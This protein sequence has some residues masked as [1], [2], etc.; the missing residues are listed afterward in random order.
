MSHNPDDTFASLPN[1]APTAFAPGVRFDDYELI[2]KLGQGGMGE[3]WRAKEIPAAGRDVAIKFVPK[4]IEK[5]EEEMERVAEMFRQV[6]DMQHE[7]ICPL[8]TMKRT[9]GFGTYIVMKFIRGVT[10][11]KFA[12]EVRQAHG[13]FPLTAL[14]EILRP[15]AAALDYAHKK[16]VVHRDIKPGNIMLSGDPKTLEIEDVQ[17][18]DFGLAAT[19]RASMSRVSQ[20]KSSTSGTRPYMAPEQWN[21][22]FQDAATDQY[23]LAV[24]VYELLAGVFPFDSDD[25]EALRLCVLNVLPDPIPGQ[26]PEVN[27]AVL[28]ALSKERKDR[29]PSCREFIV[30]MEKLAVTTV[31]QPKPAEP[32]SKPKIAVRLGLSADQKSARPMGNIQDAELAKLAEFP[33]LQSLNLAWCRQITDAGLAHLAELTELQ[34]LNLT[35]CEEITDAGLSHLAWLENLQTLNLTAC[36][37]ITDAGLVCLAKLTNLRTLN[38]SKCDEI[39][40]AGLAHLAGMTQLQELHLEE[41]EELTDAGMTHLAGLTN[42]RTLSVYRCDKIPNLYPHYLGGLTQLQSLIL[43]G[44]KEVDGRKHLAEP[45]PPAPPQP[46][47]IA[48]ELLRRL[49]PSIDEK[50]AQPVAHI[51]DAELAQLARF[52]QLRVLNLE[53]CWLVTNAGLAHLTKLTELQTL[54]LT[55]CDKIT[56]AG[57]AHLARMRKLQTLSL[58]KCHQITDAGLER[59]DS[60]PLLRCLILPSGMTDHE[61]RYL[62]GLS[63]PPPSTEEMT[64][65][66]GLSDD[67]KIARPMT[68]TRFCILF[69][70]VFGLIIGGG[71]GD[72]LLGC[73]LGGIAGAGIGFII[74]NFLDWKFP[75]GLR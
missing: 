17:L 15:I 2:E 49:R 13:A 42:L 19:F 70:V 14:L 21:G 27:A 39:T 45:L 36:D 31:S 40:D 52:P 26:P 47:P 34:T 54:Y 75:Q 6:H 44:G 5:A 28:R 59:L 48:E 56:D 38:L 71:I 73:I 50:S 41:C 23:S 57:M 62:R 51:T 22:K 55:G 12:R 65:R 68:N 67:G 4:D 60:L 25:A 74:G 46:P 11:T 10:L 72:G 53:G 30:A 32:R 61:L 58:E 63:Q 16:N 37:R 3:I 43:P 7:H 8:Y 18:I 66:L 24:S 35:G 9:P 29:F 20:Q 64:E 69:M 1:A 33:R